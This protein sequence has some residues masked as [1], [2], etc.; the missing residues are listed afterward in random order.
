MKLRS[1]DYQLQ[2]QLTVDSSL[3]RELEIP[4]I[5]GLQR[6]GDVLIAP[7]ESGPIGE[8]IEVSS[9]EV[10]RGEM[11]GN[12]H[13]LLGE[14]PVH[15]TEAPSGLLLGHLYVPEGSVGVLAHPEHGFN[16]V[17]PGHYRISRQRE[18]AD[19]IRMVLD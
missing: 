11:G 15:W 13:L 5:A 12:T 7:V 4:V 3:D 1:V 18:Q 2:Y 8:P 10:I 6:Q 16:R 17:A 14:G 9:L 19:Q